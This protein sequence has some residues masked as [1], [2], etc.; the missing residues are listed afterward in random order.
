MPPIPE[1]KSMKRIFGMA[2][3]RA[4]KPQIF[5]YFLSEAEPLDIHYQAEPG[6]ENLLL[7][8][9]VLCAFAVD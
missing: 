1:N 6:N 9:R 7:F 8:L 5:Y 3:K 2:I 4:V